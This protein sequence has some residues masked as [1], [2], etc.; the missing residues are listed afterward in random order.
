MGQGKG[1][2]IIK[3]K[4]NSPGFGDINIP[5]AIIKTPAGIHEFH[6]YVRDLTIRIGSGNAGTIA[7]DFV[8]N[9]S[10]GIINV[11]I[12]SEDGKGNTAIS[13]TREYQGLAC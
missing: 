9:N 1:E 6:N 11:A 13:M 12:Q 4:N 2:T 10:G 8:T 7:L 5:K 3:L